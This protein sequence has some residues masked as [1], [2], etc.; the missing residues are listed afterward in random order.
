[1]EHKRK[2][3]YLEA[4]G[5]EPMCIVS[6]LH[7]VIF[8]C[9]VFYIFIFCFSFQQAHDN[10]HSRSEKVTRRLLIFTSYGM[11]SAF[12]TH[13]SHTGT[14]RLIGHVRCNWVPPSLKA[15]VINCSACVLLATALELG[16]IRQKLLLYMGHYF[17]P[18][19]DLIPR[20]FQSYFHIP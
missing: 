11:D 5:F 14:L 15:Q 13:V 3:C 18:H 4:F 1:M 9:S 6:F 16:P 8:P 20:S 10:E 17:P 19:S 12:L 7:H 2:V